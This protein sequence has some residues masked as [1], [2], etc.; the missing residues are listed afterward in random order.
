MKKLIAALLAAMMVLSLT[1]C[2]GSADKTIDVQALAD[3]LKDKVPYSATLIAA[4]VE[5]MEYRFDPPEGTTL[6]G[7]MADG[8]TADM[9][10]VAQCASAD[11]AKTL[12]ANIGTYLDDLKREA[13]L[14]QPEEVARLDEALLQ[15]SGSVVVLCISD[16]TA[17]ASTVLEGYLK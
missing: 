15:Q 11:D 17:A 6:A 4:A 3:D 13:N 8:S 10:V 9:V 2:G 1:A 5:D 7:Y 16:D 12:C 14:Y